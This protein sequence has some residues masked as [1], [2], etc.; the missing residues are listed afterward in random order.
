MAG[1]FR[2][3]GVRAADMKELVRQVH[4]RTFYYRR[5]DGTW[6]DSLIPKGESPSLDETVEAWSDTFFAL[7]KAHPELRRYAML[8][9]D[10]VVSLDGKTI[11][12][13]FPTE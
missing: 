8:G 9:K 5:A 12:I 10:M 2:A 1:A 7:V 4:D 13:T 6:Y 3:A 11:R